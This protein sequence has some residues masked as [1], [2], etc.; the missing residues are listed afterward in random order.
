ME[1]S[2]QS[3]LVLVIDDEPG[4]REGCGRILSRMGCR[5]ALAADG[6]AGLEALKEDPAD[7]VLLDLKMPGLDGMEVLRRISE[8][9]PE[10]LVIVITGFGTVETATEAMKL[11]AYDFIAKPFQPDRLRVTVDRAI[12]RKR[13]LEERRRT[14]ADLDAEKSRIRTIV[15]ALPNGLAVIGRDG[16]VVL[17]NP[18]F[19]QACNLDPATRPGEH[20]S[21]Y[22]PDQ[23]FGDLV[24]AISQGKTGNC[25]FATPD[26][27]WLLAR[28]T[29]VLSEAG[30]HLGIVLLLIDIT[31][32]KLLDRLKSEFVAKVSHELRSPLSTIHLQLSLLLGERRAPEPEKDRRLLARVQEKTMGLIATISDLLDISR[33][34]SGLAARQFEEVNLSELLAGVIE[35]HLPQAQSRNQSLNLRLPPEKLPALKADP[36]ALESVFNNLVSNAIKYT[37]EGGEILVTSGCEGDFFKVAVQDNGFGIE[38]QYLEMIFEKFFR[39]KNEKTR[40]VTGTGLGLPIVKAVV[41]SMGGKI[42]VQSQPAQGSTFTVYL[43]LKP[44]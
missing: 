21:F 10:T 16:R 32:F 22:L 24:A 37:Q 8:F 25:E 30:E 12:E 44:K 27:R 11:G 6:Q 29:E 1:S 42:E 23:A 9:Y 35:S 15:Q 19:C 31:E 17:M 20:I 38:P 14:L 4:I 34:D 28:F 2:R 3:V 7:I 40:Y 33:I 41:E 36:V 5:V 26:G 43:P 13:L 18:A 39:V